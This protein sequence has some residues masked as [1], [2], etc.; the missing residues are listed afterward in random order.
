M[1]R[2]LLTLAVAASIPALMA[3]EAKPEAKAKPYPLDKCIV[4]GDKFEGSDMT[5]HELVFEG[6]TVKL[7]CKSC[8][9]DFNKDKAGYLKKISEE[10]AKNAKSKGK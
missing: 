8:L 1:K 6:Q 10:V 5:P 7:C 2:F 3:A 4:S 9:K